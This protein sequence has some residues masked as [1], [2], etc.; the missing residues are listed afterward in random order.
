MNKAFEKSRGEKVNILIVVGLFWSLV[1]Y[2]A[3][4]DLN[5]ILHADSLFLLS[6]S[7]A[8][9]LSHC[10]VGVLVGLWNISDC[11]QLSNLDKMQDG[12][13]RGVH[14]R[15]TWKKNFGL[16]HFLPC[17]LIWAKVCNQK[18]GMYISQLV[19]SWQGLLSLHQQVRMPLLLRPCEQINLLHTANEN[20]SCTRQTSSRGKCSR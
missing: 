8:V 3:K 14:S 2:T 6:L 20:S 1:A 4:S 11:T 13:L 19:V 9:C 12:E 10:W 17:V 18:R 16:V 7:L 15:H 5:E